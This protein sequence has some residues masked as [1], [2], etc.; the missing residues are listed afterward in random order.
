[1]AS[2]TNNYVVTKQ[3][4]KEITVD[5]RPSLPPSSRLTPP[6]E[7][8]HSDIKANVFLLSITFSVVNTLFCCFG[9][10]SNRTLLSSI[11]SVDSSNA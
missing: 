10:L 5:E 3:R 4:N 1:M 6:I 8:L 2:Q 9:L 11:I 7:V